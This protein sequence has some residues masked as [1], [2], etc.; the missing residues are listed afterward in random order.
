VGG[1][2]VFATGTNWWVSKLADGSV[3][4]P[5][6]LL[7]VAIP[8]VTSTLTQITRNVLTT[9]GSGPGGLLAPSQPDWSHF[10]AAGTAGPRAVQGA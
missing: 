9:L 2:G 5:A 6:P 7:P 1:G 3:P 8:G 4:V 10:Y